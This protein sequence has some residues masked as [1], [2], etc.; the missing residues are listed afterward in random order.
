MFFMQLAFL[1]YQIYDKDQNQSAKNYTN[2]YP[3]LGSA[4]VNQV[5][6]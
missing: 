3:S 5:D 1:Y 2:H 6:K 4:Y